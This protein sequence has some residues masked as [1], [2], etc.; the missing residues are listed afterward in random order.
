MW[1]C[2]CAYPPRTLPFLCPKAL[3]LLDF[4]VGAPAVPEVHVVVSV[5]VAALLAPAHAPPTVGFLGRPAP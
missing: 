2:H 3:R 4:L 5:G 1:E